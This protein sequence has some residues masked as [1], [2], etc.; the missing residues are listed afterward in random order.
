ML[1]DLSGLKKRVFA[2]PL[3]NPLFKE[4]RKMMNSGMNIRAVKKYEPIQD[5]QTVTLLGNLLVSP[6]KFIAHLRR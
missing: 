4:Y 1:D 2:M 6:E 5:M 3:D